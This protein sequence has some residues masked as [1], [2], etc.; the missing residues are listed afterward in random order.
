[1]TQTNDYD[2]IPGTYVYDAERGRFLDVARS[3]RTPED[4]G[5]VGTD[6]LTVLVPAFVVTILSPAV[7]ETFPAAEA[8]RLSARWVAGGSV[9]FGASFFWSVV[10]SGPYSAL[11]S[12]MV[13]LF[14]YVLLVRIWPSPS[15]AG[16]CMPLCAIKQSSPVVLSVTVLPPVFGAVMMSRLKPWPRRTSMGTT[17]RGSAGGC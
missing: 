12:S 4:R 16:M 3:A 14:T 6:D 1:M 8:L 9:L 7:H 15:A 11:A 17:V 2:N 5:S 13:T 10:L